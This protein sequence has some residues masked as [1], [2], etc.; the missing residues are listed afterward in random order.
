[1]IFDGDSQAFLK[2]P[3]YQVCNVF[4]NLKKEVRDAVNFLQADKHH[5]YKLISTL[6]A[7]QFSTR[8]YY[9]YWWAWLSILK[10]LKVTSLQ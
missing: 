6:W 2:F 8:G 1:M 3:K 10:V 5:F 7:S 9:N 4:T